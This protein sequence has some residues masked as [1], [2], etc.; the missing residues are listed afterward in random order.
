VPPGGLPPASERFERVVALEPLSLNPMGATIAHAAE[1]VL[2][3]AERGMTEL[4]TARRTV[5]MIGRDRFIG[6][7]LVSR[8]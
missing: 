4:R 3:I 2:M 8:R 7:V 5:E 1:A 6:C